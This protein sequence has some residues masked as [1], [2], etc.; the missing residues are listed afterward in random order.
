MIISF[1]FLFFLFDRGLDCLYP[2]KKIVEFVL[3]LNDVSKVLLKD[4][5]DEND[6]EIE[7]QSIWL[8]LNYVHLEVSAY[9][10]L[11]ECL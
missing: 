1:F 4:S 6:Y 2:Q 11:Y 7:I 10:C 5:K 9:N 8:D 3:K